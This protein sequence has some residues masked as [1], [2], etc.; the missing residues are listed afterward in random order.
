M[1]CSVLKPETSRITRATPDN[2]NSRKLS[3]NPSISSSRPSK[4]TLLP[5]FQGLDIYSSTDK[6]ASEIMVRLQPGAPG[7]Q[8]GYGTRG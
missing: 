3:T 6:A 8:R 7:E 1:Y 5:T 4:L 2:S